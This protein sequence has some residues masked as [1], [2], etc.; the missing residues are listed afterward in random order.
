[1]ELYRVLVALCLLG[2][3][4]IAWVC[5]EDDDTRQL[6]NILRSIMG[7]LVGSILTAVALVIIGGFVFA[8]HFV[9]FGS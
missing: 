1:M 6:L 2:G 7:L 9:I 3:L 5:W 4:F 8:V